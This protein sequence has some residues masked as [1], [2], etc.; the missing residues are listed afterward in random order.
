M[1]TN[2]LINAVLAL[3][4]E[5]PSDAREML[6]SPE[7]RV[8]SN[9]VQVRLAKALQTRE[10]AAV[11]RILKSILRVSLR[12]DSK[13]AAKSLDQKWDTSHEEAFLQ[14]VAFVESIIED[15]V[16]EFKS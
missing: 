9:E 8:S 5:R 4:E 7:M 3:V 16:H 1:S 14:G 6:R 11:T 13:A 12:A 10:D 2:T 15:Y